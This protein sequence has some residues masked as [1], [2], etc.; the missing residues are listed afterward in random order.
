MNATSSSSAARGP[1]DKAIVDAA[2][3][4]RNP[5][6]RDMLERLSMAQTVGAILQRSGDGS[7]SSPGRDRTWPS[8]RSMPTGLDRVRRKLTAASDG[9]R[10]FVDIIAAGLSH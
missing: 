5:A 4:P 6:A 7:I 9:D 10:K 2:E 3:Q 8:H 1:K